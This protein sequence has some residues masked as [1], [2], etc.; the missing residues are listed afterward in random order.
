MYNPHV[1]II[2]SFVQ[3][4]ANLNINK[5]EIFEHIFSLRNIAHIVTD[6]T[7]YENVNKISIYRW[8]VQNWH[9]LYR[10]ILKIKINA[11]FRV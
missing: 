3:A 1:F 8:P 11:Q 2:R 10:R 5:F 7:G 4:L 6:I 9:V